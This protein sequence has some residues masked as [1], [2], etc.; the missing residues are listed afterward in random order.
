[1]KSNNT[2]PFIL[3]TSFLFFSFSGFA[4]NVD[5]DD[6]F[7]NYVHTFDYRTENIP[8]LEERI[9]QYE[10]I[11]DRKNKKQNIYLLFGKL[12][13]NFYATGDPEIIISICDKLEKAIGND[14][15]YYLILSMAHRFKGVYLSLYNGDYEEIIS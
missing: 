3:F 12:H 6:E 8:I 1:M 11:A 5:K 9:N 14:K 13:Y 4:Q 15:N 2:L 10:K 7:F